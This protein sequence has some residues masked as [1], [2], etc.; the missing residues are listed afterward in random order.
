MDPR[1]P[2]NFLNQVLGRELKITLVCGTFEGILQHVDP[3]RSI[4]LKRVKNVETGRSVPG[5]KMF[6]GHEIK[7]VEMLNEEEQG[8]TRGTGTPDRSRD[9]S[10]PAEQMH[11]AW[12]KQALVRWPGARANPEGTRPD[13]PRESERSQGGPTP[14]PLA[15]ETA[16]L[17]SPYKYNPGEGG[18]AVAF[19]I[20]DQF[21]QR[22]SSA[23]ATTT[24]VYLFDIHLLGHRAF[25][26][27]LQP[28]MEDQG[29]LKVMHDCRWLSD[30]LAHQYGIVLANVFDTQV[31]D[32]LQF[33]R[34]TGGHLP[35]RLSTLQ[36]SLMRH[37][38]LPARQV[39]FLGDR[40]RLM[41]ENA[42]LWLARP[43]PPGLPKVLAL[44]A[45]Y[46]LP[47]R[48]ALLDGMMADLTAVVDG[49][50]NAFREKPAH[51]LGGLQASCLELP[52]ELRQLT[53]QRTLRREQAVKAYGLNARGLLVRPRPPGT[54]EEA[55]GGQR[56]QRLPRAAAAAAA[57]SPRPGPPEADGWQSQGV[58][59]R[60][61]KQP[62]AIPRPP[63]PTA[64]AEAGAGEPGGPPEGKEPARPPRRPPRPCLSLQ[65]EIEGLLKDRGHESGRP[66]PGAAR[67]ALGA[68]P[69]PPSPPACPSPEEVG[70]RGTPANPGPRARPLKGAATFFYKRGSPQAPRH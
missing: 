32:V 6:F 60:P 70:P 33:S 11:P 59:C 28:V 65:E 45:A 27:G 46:L 13:R 35:H 57:S 64:K 10:G 22:F 24:R 29:V 62:R 5:V 26:N 14:T 2:C 37:L 56:G 68:S 12:K 55:A 42:R 63:L 69:P 17:R 16:P 8:V 3:S 30:C 38:K 44:E 15:P 23:V 39:A 66:R 50:L 43:L 25:K 7:N 61:S 1:G 40:Q 18:E 20:V 36:D 19:T 67:R 9:G 53:E 58:G 34:E 51:L 54:E 47:L 31:A 48:L 49:Y 4:V 21:Q 41:E 52:E